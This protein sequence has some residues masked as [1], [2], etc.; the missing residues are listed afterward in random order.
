[1]PGYIIFLLHLFYVE[2]C[3]DTQIPPVVLQLPAAFSTETCHTG[4]SPGAAGCALRVPGTLQHLGLLND[5][6]RR[7]TTPK[8]PNDA[9]CRTYSYLK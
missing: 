6:L 9:F 7:L 3:L 5:T 4:C 8:S 2:L 1:M